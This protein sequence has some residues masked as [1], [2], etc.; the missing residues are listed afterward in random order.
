VTPGGRR[1]GFVNRLGG[2]RRPQPGRT[3]LTAGAA[4]QAVAHQRASPPQFPTTRLRVAAGDS[5]TSAR[6]IRCRGMVD[7]WEL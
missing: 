6:A 3:S 5:A 4:H 2:V 7:V 1:D